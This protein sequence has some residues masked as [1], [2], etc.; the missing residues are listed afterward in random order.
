MG[1]KVLKKFNTSGFKKLKPGLVEYT[2]NPSTQEAEVGGVKCQAGLNIEFQDSQ[3]DIK[4][5]LCQ[6]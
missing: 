4:K 2:F 1:K 5:T 6:K 3:D